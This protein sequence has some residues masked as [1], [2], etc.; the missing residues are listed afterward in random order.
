MTVSVGV[1]K[2]ECTRAYVHVGMGIGV[3]PDK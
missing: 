2:R 3:I 1:R